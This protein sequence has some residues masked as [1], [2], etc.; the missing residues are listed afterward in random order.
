M[1]QENMAIVRLEYERANA[2]YKVEYEGERDL[3][4]PDFEF[5]G[6]DIAPAM[7]IVRGYDAVWDALEEYWDM[8][9][10]FHVEL[11]E[12]LHADE[13]RVVTA[14]RDGGR[15]KG[16]D[17]EIWNDLFH[18]W[19]FRDRKIVRLSSHNDRSRALKAAGLSE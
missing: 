11:K 12:V 8:F 3:F 4:D 10:D 16:S 13:D 17:A 15:M 9:E 2:D 5:D 1:S 6:R 19:T 18:V 14:V 7:G